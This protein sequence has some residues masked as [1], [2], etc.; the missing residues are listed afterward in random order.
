[1]G[2]SVEDEI[3]YGAPTFKQAKHVFW[4]RLKQTVLEVWR[5]VRPK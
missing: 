5:A 2:G 1:M 3:W 4:R